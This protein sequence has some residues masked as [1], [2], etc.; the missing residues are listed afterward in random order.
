MATF[1]LVGCALPALTE[2]GPASLMCRMDANFARGWERANADADLTLILNPDY[3][4]LHPDEAVRPGDLGLGDERWSVAP[5]RWLERVQ[6]GLTSLR[7]LDDRHRWLLLADGLWADAAAEALQAL[8]QQ[9]EHLTSPAEQ[10]D[11]RG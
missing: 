6:R 1:A 11:R 7:M 2:A 9:V 3:G 5:E 10:P 4:L 8:G